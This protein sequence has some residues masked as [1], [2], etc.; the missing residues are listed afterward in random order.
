MENIAY[1]K[2]SLLKSKK[3]Y[4]FSKKGYEL[5]DKK[6]N[7]LI[8]ELMS[9]YEKSKDIEKEIVNAYKKAYKALVNANI[10]LGSSV[11]SDLAGSIPDEEEFNVLYTS[12]MGV[13]I[14]KIIFK[15]RTLEN[16]YGFYRSNALFDEA[17]SIFQEIKYL[18]YQISEIEDGI[19]KLSLE[20][21]KTAKRA[22]ALEKIQIP[23]YRNM[24]KAISENLEEKER[25]DFFRMKVIKKKHRS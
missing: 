4:E 7:V 14:P 11:V 18:I 19:Y 2:A 12:V 17:C 5:L 16:S 25:E 20:I 13:E 1:T 21:K 3:R 8:R 22:N 24:I 10:S 15:R 6:R 9:L 23:K